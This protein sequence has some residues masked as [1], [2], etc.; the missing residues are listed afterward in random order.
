MGSIFS[1]IL[2]DRLSTEGYRPAMIRFGSG[3][4]WLT[5]WAGGAG[6]PSRRLGFSAMRLG[7]AQDDRVV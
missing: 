6:D 5:R 3:A 1:R 7:Y 2:L 4:I